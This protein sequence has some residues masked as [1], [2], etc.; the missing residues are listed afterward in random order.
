MQNNNIDIYVSPSLTHE[1][2]TDR[3]HLLDVTSRDEKQ[4]ILADEPREFLTNGFT[5]QFND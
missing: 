3:V 2:V 5:Q 4:K 1:V